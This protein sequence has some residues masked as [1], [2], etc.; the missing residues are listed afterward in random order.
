MILSNLLS[1]LTTRTFRGKITLAYLVLGFLMLLLGI[2]GWVYVQKI[3]INPYQ[4]ILE[5]QVPVRYYCNQISTSISQSTTNLT[6]YLLTKEDDYKIQRQK[7]WNKSYQGSV[8]SLMVYAIAWKQTQVIT[9]VYDVRLK[10][11]RL[12]SEQDLLEK[13]TQKE[14]LSKSIGDIQ[15]L[16]QDIHNTLSLII[17][18]QKEELMEAQSNIAFE[19]NN[20]EWFYIPFVI[21]VLFGLFIWVG[22]NITSSLFGRLEQ[23]EQSL[24]AIDNGNIPADFDTIEDELYHIGR[25]INSISEDLKQIKNFAS[26]VGNGN[27]DVDFTAFGA[28]GELGTAF[29][30]M[31]DSLKE[32]SHKEQELN[33]ITSGILH[34]SKILQDNDRDIEQLCDAF[35][36]ELIGYLG[37]NQ[38][39]IYLIEDT[40]LVLH[41]F[42]AFEIKKYKQKEI[43]IEEGLLGEAFQERRTIYIEDLPDDYINVS[44][45]LG[46][47]PPSYLLLVPLQ[48]GNS[49]E[50]VLE[51]ASFKVIE[52]YK[53]TF[54]EKICEDMA[55][56]IVSVQGKTHEHTLLKEAQE[57]SDRLLAQEEVM[58]K[59]LEELK[60]TQEKMERRE[61]GFKKMIKDK[62][63]EIEDARGL[64]RK[65]ADIKM[66]KWLEENK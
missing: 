61:K 10:A 65:N 38:A 45:G 33:W 12:R 55:S 63:K 26:E 39:G 36:K 52:K 60:A 58:R 7:N 6:N 9:L 29:L 32:V 43:E 16:S 4:T 41:S 54:I 13:S 22:F 46:N 50:G 21:I 31:R 48:M 51:I 64:E 5:K 14:T 30:K 49:N 25:K 40:K 53:I 19:I 62:N 1:Y 37:I 11:S 44:S 59:S 2:L 23:V 34:F 8:D 18:L 28:G 47:A 57:T 3:A 56:T 20:L 24:T 42:Y 17:T 27:F 35:I 15:L 66:Q